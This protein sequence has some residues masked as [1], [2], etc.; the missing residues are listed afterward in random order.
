MFASGG[1][2][3]EL[4]GCFARPPPNPQ[5]IAAV[6]EYFLSTYWFSLVLGAKDIMSHEPQSLPTRNS[7][8]L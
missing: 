3:G 2:N 7:K 4:L 5:M 6:S 1:V 8:D